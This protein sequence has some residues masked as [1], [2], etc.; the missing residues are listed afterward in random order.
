MRAHEGE[1]GAGAIRANRRG[2]GRDAAR[3]GRAPVAEQIVQQLVAEGRS[4]ESEGGA[5]IGVS[6][7]MPTVPSLD[8][9]ATWPSRS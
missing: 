4:G 9:V 1:Q 3:H 6:A 5:L 7:L 8:A 2:G